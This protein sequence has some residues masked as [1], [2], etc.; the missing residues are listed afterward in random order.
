MHRSAPVCPPA[1]GFNLIE[2]MVVLA[3]VGVLTAIAFPGIS[4]LMASNRMA[5][6]TN[7]FVASTSLARSEAIRA[8]AV[9]GV[10]PSANGTSCG[11]TADW[12]T[13]WI[14]WVDQDDDGTFDAAELVRVETGPPASSL[15]LT[16]DFAAL[17]FNMRGRP[18]GTTTRQMVLAPT[19][20]KTGQSRRRVV[21][22]GT[23]RVRTTKE[24][25]SG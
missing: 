11:V 1:K 15:T 8:G 13:G 3:I 4:R 16:A 6:A 24:A 20:C 12:Q 10:C 22:N 25:C 14:V 18:V 19:S 2:V 7:A 9:A 5:A 23:G 21:V 17:T